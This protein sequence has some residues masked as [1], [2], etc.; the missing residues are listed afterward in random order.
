MVDNSGGYRFYPDGALNIVL[1]YGGIRIIYITG[2]AHGTHGI[3]SRLN[4]RNF[5]QQRQ[6]NKQDYVIIAA[7]NGFGSIMGRM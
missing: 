1:W 6:M 7:W 5:P 2:D 3:A 4:T